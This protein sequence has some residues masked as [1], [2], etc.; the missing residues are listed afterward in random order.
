MLSTIKRL[1]LRPTRPTGITPEAVAWAY[2]LVLGREPSP[3]DIQAH[4]NHPDLQALR[5][6]FFSSEEFRCRERSLCGPSLD[7]F[8]PALDIEDEVED[9]L[10][11][12]LL[13]HIQRSWQQLGQNE[14][15]WSVIS[16]EQFKQANLIQHRKQFYQSGR[17]DVDRLLRT[18]RRHACF[19]EGLA[20][21]TVLE[22]GCGVGR[23]TH[24]LANHFRQVYAYDISTSHLALAKTFTDELGLNNIHYRQISRPRDVMS[25]PKVDVVVTL[26]VLQHNPPPVIKLILRGLLEALKQGG[27]AYFQLLTYQKGYSFS[28]KTYLT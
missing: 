24:A 25:L 3:A 5:R 9:E 16:V 19:T 18:F 20:D 1:I 27:I 22:Y 6:A 13:A 17:D 23:M 4:L 10:L 2:R 21:K 15:H 8:E 14:P 26:I 7:G 28:A 12:K 11:E